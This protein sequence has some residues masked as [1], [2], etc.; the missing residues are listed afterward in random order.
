MTSAT[1]S[2]PI[3]LRERKRL[4]TRAALEQAAV[5]IVLRDG[6]DQAT[7]DAMCAE[8]NVSPRTFFNYFESKEDAILGVFDEKLDEASITECVAASS[9][10]DILESIMDVLFKLLGPSVSGV[11]LQKSRIEIIKQNPHLLGRHIAQMT[12]MSEQLL[13]AIRML[14]SQDPRFSHESTDE[15]SATAEMLLAIGG[16]ALRVA[17]REWVAS[18]G[19]RTN[20]QLRAAELA[21]KVIEQLQ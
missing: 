19:E 7:V 21:R 1:P 5:K 11:S 12:R 20:I 10:D 18:G 14:V 15:Q 8:A 9:T 3:G 13:V 17:V 2:Q 4:E 6:F 16:G